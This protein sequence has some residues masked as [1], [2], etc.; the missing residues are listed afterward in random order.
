MDGV[1]V[2]VC[3]C[4]RVSL[5]LSLRGVARRG[6]QRVRERRFA[7][8]KGGSAP[9]LAREKVCAPPTPPRAPP[10]RGAAPPPSPRARRQRPMPP[11]GAG[12]GGRR[13]VRGCQPP[14]SRGFGQSGPCFT[15]LA[16]PP[17]PLPPSPLAP[18]GG[19]G[20]QPTRRRGEWG[21]A[22]GDGGGTGRGVRLFGLLPLTLVIALPPCGPR[23]PPPSPTASPWTRRGRRRPS[24]W[25]EQRTWCVVVGEEEGEEGNE[26]WQE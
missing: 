25:R 6:G 24:G 8:K 19:G 1:C 4:A 18:D 3:V 22:G 17:L 14:C 12:G 20:M 2:C 16:P 9:T 7:R 15:P 11:L 5:Y 26:F 13:R 23:P 10:R 21:A